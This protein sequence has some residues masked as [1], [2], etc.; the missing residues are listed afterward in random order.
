MMIDRNE[1]T[2]SPPRCPQQGFTLLEVLVAFVILALTLAIIYQ[3]AGGSVRATI[4]GEQQTYALTLAESVV[5]NFRTVPEGGMVRSGE[6]ENGYRWQL[7][8]TL[9]PV[10]EEQRNRTA[11]PLY[12]V[13]VQVGWDRGAGVTLYSVLPQGES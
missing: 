6:L 9:R 12:D 10:P 7:E 1:A 5:N 8:A 11:L 2:G 13:R 4:K 3:A